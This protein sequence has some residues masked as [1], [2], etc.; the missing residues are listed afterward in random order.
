MDYG[1]YGGGFGRKRGHD[2][3]G[4][5]GMGMGMGM[6]SD[7]STYGYGGGHTSRD[8]IRD[9]QVSQYIIVLSLLCSFARYQARRKMYMQMSHEGTRGEKRRRDA[10]D[11]DPE[12]KIMRKLFVKNLPPSATETIVREYFEQFGVV[13]QCDVATKQD[14]ECKGFGFLVFSK[15]EGVNIV[16]ENRP[17][18]ID[19]KELHTKRASLVEDK[20]TDNLSVT[21]I[22]IGS[23]NSF[24]F[25]SGTGGLDASISDDDLKEY[26]GQYGNVTEV[27][28][29]Y[30]KDTERKKGVGFVTFDDE[31]PV[32]KIVLIGAH[33]IKGRALEAQKAISE[34]KM[35]DIRAGKNDEDVKKP[36]DPTARCMRRLFVRRIQDDTTLEKFKEFFEQFGEVVDADI[37][38]H[39]KTGKRASYGFVTFKTMEETD[40]C[41]KARPHEIEDKEVITR[42]A[43]DDELPE[44][45]DCKKVFLGA[46][47]GKTTKTAGLGPE[48]SDE[49]LKEYFEQYGVV[50]SVKQV[51]RQDGLHKGVGF[52]EYED[53]DSVDKVV[54]MCVHIIKER[55]VEAKKALSEHQVKM[56]NM[57]RMEKEE[58]NMMMKEMRSGGRGMGMRGMGMGMGMGG[59]GGMGMGMGGMG[60]GSM[61][62]MMNMMMGG[63]GGFGGGM[64]M[65][66]GNHQTLTILIL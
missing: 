61:N 28:Q 55:E 25:K 7:G 45:A 39:K 30:H 24:T 57:R 65:G 5:Y 58:R 35:N 15:A 40:A 26:F 60:M 42:R 47:G 19:D 32:D 14:G 49:E 63:F 36:T 13:E 1:G 31:D 23:P 48:I 29:L 17:H 53:P 59:F 38:L 4:G 22:F 44:A 66:G 16:Q 8:N 43:M 2:D 9:Q 64:G 52:I 10:D 41:M 62:D 20:M 6:M 3:M 56:Q 34:K 37:P 46:P 27:L 11:F 54:L 21:K 33:I 51:M 18:K 12:A 50:T